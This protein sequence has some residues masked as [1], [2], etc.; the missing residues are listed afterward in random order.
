MFIDFC[1]FLGDFVS[2]VDDEED[3]SGEID[4]DDG[5]VKEGVVE[6]FN[7]VFFGDIV[8][9]DEFKKSLILIFEGF[10]GFVFERLFG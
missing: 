6:D 4:E 2:E 7:Y 5:I 1:N 3:D 10:F 8:F 9:V